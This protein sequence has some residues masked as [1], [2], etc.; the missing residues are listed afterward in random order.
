MSIPTLQNNLPALLSSEKCEELRGGPS[1]QRT[2][3]ALLSQMACATKHGMGNCCRTLRPSYGLSFLIR[4]H[5]LRSFY[6]ITC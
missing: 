3:A 6:R 2:S 4:L 1:F 5:L